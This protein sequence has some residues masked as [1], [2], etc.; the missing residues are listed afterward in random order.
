MNWLTL[1]LEVLNAMSFMLVF[2]KTE[3]SALRTTSF[4]QYASSFFMVSHEISLFIV[5]LLYVK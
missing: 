1:A 2:E 4:S 3:V 5:C